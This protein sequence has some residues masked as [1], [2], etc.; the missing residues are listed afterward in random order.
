[1]EKTNMT[2]YNF[3]L[4]DEQE[5]DTIKNLLPGFVFKCRGLMYPFVKYEDG[6]VHRVNNG[7]LANLPETLPVSKIVCNSFGDTTD[8]FYPAV[9]CF[10]RVSVSMQIG[11]D[12][13][14]A[15]TMQG[16]Q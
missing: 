16:M 4:S 9:L 11:I 13:M 5:I 12:F 8:N 15:L 14:T 2:C 7:E 6:T 10:K 3:K 1:M